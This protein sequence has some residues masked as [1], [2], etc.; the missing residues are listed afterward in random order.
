MVAEQRVVHPQRRGE[1]SQRRG[2]FAR[3]F[4][5]R[6]RTCVRPVAPSTRCI[7][8]SIAC[9]HLDAF[10]RIRVR[11]LLRQHR[12]RGR[13]LANRVEEDNEHSRV[14][15]GALV[16]CASSSAAPGKGARPATR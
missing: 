13:R 7:V 10:T 5:P 2:G 15:V 3:S 6:A 11:A 14:D 4:I 9:P 16:A 8:P 1:F 12:Q